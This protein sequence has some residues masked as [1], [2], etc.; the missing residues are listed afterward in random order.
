VAGQ[1]VISGVLRHEPTAGDGVRGWIISSRHGVLREARVHAAEASMEAG[2]IEVE[3]GDTLDFVVDV[4]D[5]LDSDQFVWAPGVA[6]GDGRWAAADGF[7]ATGPG[8]DYLQPWEQYAQV[9]LLS[10]EFAF[11]D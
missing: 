8:P 1:A 7:P 3:V 2:P 4:A 6:M 9:L 5:G 11:V 10:N